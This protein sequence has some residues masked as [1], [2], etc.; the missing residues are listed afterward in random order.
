MKGGLGRQVLVWLFP[1]LLLL[2]L[3]R[4]QHL[5]SRSSGNFSP[6]SAVA[7]SF[8]SSS[9][10]ASCESILVSYSQEGAKLG[11]LFPTL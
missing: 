4:W 11:F 1:N 6:T 9:F 10:Q 2:F 8:S 5:A 3:P 7:F